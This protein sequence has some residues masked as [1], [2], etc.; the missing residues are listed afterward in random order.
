MKIA[1][2]VKKI[3][4]DDEVTGASEKKTMRKCCFGMAV[5]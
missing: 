2:K 5:L 3:E 4:T 1:I